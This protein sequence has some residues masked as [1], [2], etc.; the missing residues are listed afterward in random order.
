MSEVEGRGHTTHMTRHGTP[1]KERT[2]AFDGLTDAYRR[3]RPGY[4]EPI[5]DRLRDLVHEG[6]TRPRLLIDVGSGTGISTRTLRHLFDPEPR[7]VG[8]EPGRA[9]LGAART[10]DDG[11][12]YVDG[13]AEQ[14]PYADASA[15]L[16]LAAQAVHWFDR[17]AFYAEATRVLAPG[18]VVAVLNNDR[19][20]TASAYLDAYESLM[21]EHGDSYRR[22]YRAFDTVGEMSAREGLTD[23]AEFT[24]SWVREL[25]PDEMLGMAMSSSR[26][27]AVVRNLGEERTRDTLHALTREHFPEGRVRIPYVTRLYAARR[28]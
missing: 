9:M 26:M 1:P 28:A 6:N 24:A 21:E 16:L 12:E 8:V 11:V 14:I 15:D 13:R 18:G 19:D 17:P 25:A 7:V 2:Q 10:E 22:D 5:L 20:W 4:P 3:F 23:A 27:A